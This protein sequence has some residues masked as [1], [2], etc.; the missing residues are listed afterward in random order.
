MIF[1]GIVL[2]QTKIFYHNI[3]HFRKI[4]SAVLQ[5]PSHQPKCIYFRNRTGLLPTMSAKQLSAFR[6]LLNSYALLKPKVIIS[7]LVLGLRPSEWET[8]LQCNTVS[9]W[10]D[11]NL[12]SALY[13]M[14]CES[15]WLVHYCQLYPAV[16]LL[17]FLSTFF[18]SSKRSIEIKIRLLFSSL[19]NKVQPTH[20]TNST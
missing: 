9:H 6:L 1:T 3:R 10:L 4:T 20:S 11:A 13:I 15:H 19:W 7:G 16:F 8:S 18:V 12:E 2:S 5:L 14:P 17:G